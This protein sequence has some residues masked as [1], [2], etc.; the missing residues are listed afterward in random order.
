ML[1][2]VLRAVLGMK[3]PGRVRR[4]ARRAPASSVRDAERYSEALKT[5]VPRGAHGVR[6]G[7]QLIET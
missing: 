5:S 4:I 3:K 1:R 6:V 2:V 7:D